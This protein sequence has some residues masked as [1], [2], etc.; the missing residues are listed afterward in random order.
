MFNGVVMGGQVA[1][2]TLD[3]PLAPNL[4]AGVVARAIKDNVVCAA[5]L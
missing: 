3:V 1:D 4:I 5:L 2:L